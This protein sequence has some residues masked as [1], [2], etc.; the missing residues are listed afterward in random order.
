[1]LRAVGF[2]E[3]L[4]CLG[5]FAFTIPMRYFMGNGEFIRPMGM[6]H[7]VLF[8]TFLA[9]LLVACHVK[10]WSLSVFLLGLV[11]AI[12]PFGTFIFD[13]KIKHK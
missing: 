6:T 3:G 13:H 11:A 5:L 9:V 8:L 7:G 4:S 12:I 1:M 2:M 10:K